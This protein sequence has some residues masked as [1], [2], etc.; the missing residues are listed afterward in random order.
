MDYATLGVMLAL[1]VSFAPLLPFGVHPF[2]YLQSCMCT[3]ADSD[4]QKSIIGFKLQ[5]PVRL[6]LMLNRN[7]V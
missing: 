6:T 3:P 2:I 5:L 4:R 7:C 1:S